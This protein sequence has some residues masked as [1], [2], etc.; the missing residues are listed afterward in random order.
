MLSKTIYRFDGMQYNMISFVASDTLLKKLKASSKRI[1]FSKLPAFLKSE[2]TL[3]A[4]RGMHKMLSTFFTVDSENNVNFYCFIA[5]TSYF[6]R[7]FKNNAHA[8]TTTAV[9]VDI[10]SG[11]EYHVHIYD[12][13][14]HPDWNYVSHVARKFK[15]KFHATYAGSTEAQHQVILSCR[16]LTSDEI[17]ECIKRTLGA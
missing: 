2:R 10:L 8:T 5:H 7:R 13:S 17:S 6:T 3:F 11:L 4:Y 16:Q 14:G 1:S 15:G 12:I 9:T